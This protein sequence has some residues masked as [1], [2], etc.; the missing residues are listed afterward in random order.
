M[1]HGP[2]V[3][4]GPRDPITVYATVGQTITASGDSGPLDFTAI[5]SGIASVY[6]NGTVTGT[7]PSLTCYIDVQ[8]ANQHWLQV[9][10]IG[11]ALTSGPNFTFGGFGPIA[12][13]GYVLTGIGRLRW[14]V[15]G[16]ASPTFNSVDLSVIGR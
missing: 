5:S 8:D 4:A 13:S 7:T 10:T 16:T 12:G 11:V 2:L 15:T 1:P 9:A 6:V 3:N 14:V